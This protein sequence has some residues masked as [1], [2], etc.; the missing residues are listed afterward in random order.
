MCHGKLSRQAGMQAG[1]GRQAMV[2][3]VVPGVNTHHHNLTH[4][5]PA[6]TRGSWVDV[7]SLQFFSYTQ[8]KPLKILAFPGGFP[9]S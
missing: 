3:H 8:K 2:S 5:S 7:Y 4:F 6:N 1:R 9:S